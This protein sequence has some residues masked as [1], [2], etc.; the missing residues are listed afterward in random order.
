MCGIVYAQSFNGLPV[1]DM[2]W[3]QY[4][5]QK[6][7]GTEG[8]GAFDGEHTVKAAVEKRMKRWFRKGRNE[9]DLL[10]F[11]HRYPTSTVNVR[12]AAHPFNTGNYFGDTRY[13]LV[14]NGVIHNPAE[15]RTAHEAIG[16]TYQSTLDDNSYNDSEALL[17]D[18]AL[19]MEGKQD[20][21]K[22]YGGIAFVCIKLVDGKPDKLYFG[23]NK[24]R[25][26]NLLRDADGVM[27]SSEG[28]GEEI[29][30]G[31]LYTYNYELN[32]LTSRTFTISSYDPD[33]EYE[34]SQDYK[35]NDRSVYYPPSRTT[36]GRAAVPYRDDTF[37]DGEDDFFVDNDGYAH[38]MTD[39]DWEDFYYNEG[40]GYYDD[41]AGQWFSAPHKE[42]ASKPT[43]VSEILAIHPSQ[44]QI[45]MRMLNALA[46]ADGMYEA[47]YW[48]LMGE[49]YDLEG[50]IAP[51]AAQKQEMALLIAAGEAISNQP[52]YHDDTSRHP[53]WGLSNTLLTKG[54]RS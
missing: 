21:L 23:R 54:A 37:V 13:V 31:W 46:K 34:P 7:R 17:W 51:T 40:M 14:H 6:H 52:D 12:R 3:Q 32:R 22:A 18:F 33:Y 48:K 50:T 42:V 11:H 41:R 29:K 8:F 53:L 39:D 44:N 26:L 45:D 24:G 28:A 20:A 49:Y 30:D 5:K 35:W 1:N 15:L 9:T 36:F 4:Q 16:I 2:V 27:L 47:A 10:L 38:R 19:T 25:P 43:L